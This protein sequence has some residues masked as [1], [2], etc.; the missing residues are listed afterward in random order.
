M[1]NTTTLLASLGQLIKQRLT[2]TAKE[3]KLAKQERRLI[4]E[5]GRVLP[6]IGYR[7]VSVNGRPNKREGAR[8]KRAL[9]K[10]LKCP[11]CDRRFSLQAHLARHLSAMHGKKG[12]GRRKTTHQGGIGD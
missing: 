7:L 4:Q 5:M 1:A 8:T 6:K 12:N 9:P 11:K 2:L 10:S 3:Q